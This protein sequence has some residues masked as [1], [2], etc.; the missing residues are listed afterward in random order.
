MMD[1]G[2]PEQVPYLRRKLSRDAYRL[3]LAKIGA[4]LVDVYRDELSTDQVHLVRL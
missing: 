2:G 3:A 1:V 4:S